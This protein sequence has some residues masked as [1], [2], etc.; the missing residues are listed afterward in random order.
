[1]N[2]EV[3]VQVFESNVLIGLDPGPCRLV[4]APLVATGRV[5]LNQSLNQAFGPGSGPG[6]FV[7]HAT[8]RG[9]VD[10]TAGGQAR[11]YGTQ[12]FE[13]RPDGT[14]FKDQELVTLTPL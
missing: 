5:F 13:M 4:G 14:V 10:L 12:R 2:R 1:V 7:F 8:V 3:F 9:I 11:L 6:S